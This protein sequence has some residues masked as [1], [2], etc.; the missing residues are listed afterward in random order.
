MWTATYEPYVVPLEDAGTRIRPLAAEAAQAMLNFTILRPRYL[1]PD[2]LMTEAFLRVEAPPTDDDAIERGNRPPDWTS[3]NTCSYLMRFEGNGRRFRL[4]QFLYD[5]APPACD[6]PPLWGGAV[7]PVPSVPPYVT[8][9][10]T[11]FMDRAGATSR[12][13]RTSVEMS[14][15]EGR[16]SDEEIAALFCGLEPVD[17]QF[18]R[19]LEAQPFATLTYW[20]RHDLPIVNVPYGLFRFSRTDEAE[21]GAWTAGAAETPGI[22]QP[23]L[24]PS[25]GFGLDSTGLFGDADNREAELVFTAAPGRGREVRFIL[26]AGNRGRIAWPP[27]ASSHPA[28]GETVSVN[29]TEAHVRFIDASVGPWAAV[30]EHEGTRALVMTSSAHGHDRAWFMDL[31]AKTDWS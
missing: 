1:P 8:W 10:G 24:D 31:L 16:Y 27:L 5:W 22:R 18:A 19:L 23:R 17:A 25:F 7:R 13:N 30:F 6:H 2:T 4:K 12:I 11:D 29:G 20:S 3:A 28:S 26:Q 21:R 9:V 14:I 15:S